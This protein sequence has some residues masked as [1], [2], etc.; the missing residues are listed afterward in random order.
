M[1]IRPQ[2]WSPLSALMLRSFSSYLSD[3]CQRVIINGQ[4]SDWLKILAGVPQGLV[5]GP[6]L[7]LMFINDIT[8]VVKNCNVRLFAD[9]T[10]LFTTVKDHGESAELIKQDLKNIEEWAKQWLVTFSPSKSENMV[11]S[12][13][14]HVQ[15]S[16][17]RLIFYN[18]P[19]AHV[20]A[21]KYIGL[22]ISYNLK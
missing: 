7:F 3:R 17:P 12:L 8:T 13:K 5:L 4:F 15:N 16:H 19:I 21:Q 6:L 20:R 22:W 18:M 10:C 14:P 9:D 11:V 2:F 1:N